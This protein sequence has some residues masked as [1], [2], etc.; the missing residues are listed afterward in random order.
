ML[1]RNWITLEPLVQFQFCQL[2]WMLHS[3]DLQPIALDPPYLNYVYSKNA[4]TRRQI[5]T[6]TLILHPLSS[7]EV[8]YEW[9]FNSDFRLVT[10]EICILYR[11]L[12]ALWCTYSFCLWN[13][14]KRW[15]FVNW[16]SWWRANSLG[17]SWISDT[18]LIREGGGGCG[19]YL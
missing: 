9:N 6:L 2:I 15:K 13:Y 1:L 11:I 19:G 5:H 17:A 10:P 12:P 3:N 18:I 16:V 4:Q 7:S 8:A 14:F